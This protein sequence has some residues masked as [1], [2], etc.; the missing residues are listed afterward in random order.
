M[1]SEMVCCE[2]VKNTKEMEFFLRGCYPLFRKAEKD[3]QQ[4][5]VLIGNKMFP[6]N[7]IRDMETLCEEAFQI[8]KGLGKIFC[9]VFFK[10]L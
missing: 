6:A 4:M 1:T 9:R 2:E 8:V 10:T 3:G 7:N 5:S